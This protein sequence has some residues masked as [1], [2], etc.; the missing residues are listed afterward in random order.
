VTVTVS[1]LADARWEVGRAE[2]LYRDL[3]P[4][5][6]GGR[7]IASHIKIPQG[8]PVADWVHFHTVGF[9]II[10][11]WRGWVR[12]VYED[13][14]APF[15]LESGDAVLQ[16]PRIRHQVLECSPGL[17][18]IEVASPA[19]HATA[20]DPD[21]ALPTAARRPERVFDGQRFVH[22]RAAGAPRRED[23]AL[24]VRD[25][26]I[27]AAT[28]GLVAARVARALAP[29]EIAG[30]L[31]GFVLAGAGSWTDGDAFHLADAQS[32]AIARD[33]E[34]LLVHLPR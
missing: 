12:V 15:V 26:G 11:C 18:V 20:A 8:G 22:H 25:L 1:R 32:L 4:E 2:M 7:L 13:Q 6:D 17:E 30:P 10:Y 29:A 34:I 3:V 28:G 23:G 5:R 27:G 14:G 21:L 16:P 9:Q 19:E 24:A 33:V 31:V